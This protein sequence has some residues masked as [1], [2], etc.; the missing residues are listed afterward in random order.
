MVDH[1]SLETHTWFRLPAGSTNSPG[2]LKPMSMGPWFHRAVPG[3]S[4]P[5]PR[6]RGVDQLSRAPRDMVGG[7]AGITLRNTI[8]PGGLDESAVRPGS[9]WGAGLGAQRSGHDVRRLVAPAAEILPPCPAVADSAPA[10]RGVAG[11]T[12]HTR[13]LPALR[14]PLGPRSQRR[15]VGLFNPT[16][17]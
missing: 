8:R 1:L 17:T 7:P 2:Y 6:A 16:R 12:L 13:G 4:G 14:A 9:E 3:P 5:C 15:R 11:T 10:T